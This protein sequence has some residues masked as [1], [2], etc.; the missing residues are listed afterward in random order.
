M[1][2][3]SSCRYFSYLK[4]QITRFSSSWY[5]SDIPFIPPGLGWVAF[6]LLMWMKHLILNVYLFICKDKK[7]IAFMIS[8]KK[9][10]WGRPSWFGTLCQ[11]NESEKWKWDFEPLNSVG[12]N[13]LR[14]AEATSIKYA[15]EALLNICKKGILRT[16]PR[17]KVCLRMLRSACCFARHDTN[18]GVI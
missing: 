4:L 10:L 1:V 3:I 13:P 2:I 7:L 6:D 11:G 18:S 12:E 9:Y 17:H 16:A 14:D 15:S 8:R 5:E